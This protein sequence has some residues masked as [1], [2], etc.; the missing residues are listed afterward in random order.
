MLSKF[1][2]EVKFKV[3]VPLDAS[4]LVIVILFLKRLVRHLTLVEETSSFFLI[5]PLVLGI[6]APVLPKDASW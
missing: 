3:G 1:I 2:F 4:P 5:F 6:S